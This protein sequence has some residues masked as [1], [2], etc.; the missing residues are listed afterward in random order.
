MNDSNS[1]GSGTI[2]RAEDISPPHVFVSSTL[3][4]NLLQL[5]AVLR[6]N[7]RQFGYV[8][9]M[10]ESEAFGY[11]HG[12]G[13]VYDDTIAAVETCQIFALL[14][15][16]RYGSVHPDHG[17]SITELEYEAARRHGLPVLVFVQESVKSGWDAWRRHAVKDD[18]FEHWVD[19]PRVWELLSRVMLEDACPVFVFADTHSLMQQFN[20]Q[21]ANLFGAYLRFDHGARRWLWTVQ[22][23]GRIELASSEL[24]ILSPNLYWDYQDHEYRQLVFEN[25]TQRHAIYRYLY[26][27]TTQTDDQIKELKLEYERALGPSATELAKFTPIPEV[28]FTWCAEQVIF[29]PHRAD[30]RA[31]I[32]DIC[33]DR[34][35]SRK[36][37]IEMGRTKRLLFRRQF[38]QLWS[39]YSDESIGINQR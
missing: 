18:G 8:P 11:Q 26:C 19:D 35:H 12:F 32:V 30:E 15:G 23:T 33:E 37:D 16:R 27:S 28:E 6:D 21:A 29:N 5:R 1:N 31:I 39:R 4:P 13:R 3:E 38:E 17:K 34:D 2:Y 22:Q 24:W 10:S 25:L 7:L 20:A 14:I 36:Y 9:V